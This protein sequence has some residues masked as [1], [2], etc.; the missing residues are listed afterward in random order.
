[1]F[2]PKYPKIEIMRY[3]LLFLAIPFMSAQAEAADCTRLKKIANDLEDKIERLRFTSPEYNCNEMTPKDFDLPDDS[4]GFSKD[5]EWDYRCKD[6]SAMDAQLKSI[7]N[8]IAM[9][10]GITGLKNDISQGVVTLKKFTNPEMAKEATN[11]FMKNLAVAQS[12][13]LFLGT[14]NADS[15]NILSEIVKA[16]P[17]E[18]ESY[19]SFGKLVEKFCQA[20]PIAGDSVCMKNYKI[21]QEVYEEINGFVKAGSETSRKF[22]K[23]QI[24]DFSDALGVKK[25]KE[26]YSFNQ[27]AADVK[28]GEN[29]LFSKADL[30]K[31]KD[32]PPLSNSTKFD[33]LKEMKDSLKELKESEALVGAQEIPNRFSSLINDLKKRQQFEMKSKLSLV[34]FNNA[35]KIPADL[36]DKCDQARELAIP[37]GDCLEPL[38]K[39][40]GLSETRAELNDRIEEFKYGEAHLVKLDEMLKDCIPDASLEYTAEKCDGIITSKLD[41]LVKKAAVLTKMRSKLL[42]ASPELMTLRNF[43][44]EQLESNECMAAGESNIG[45][46]SQ[47][48]GTISREVVTLSGDA[49]DV[50]LLFAKPEV[51]TDI[52]TVCAEKKEKVSHTDELCMLFEEGLKKKKVANEAT[53][54]E[55]S[56]YLNPMG[57]G[58]SEAVSDFL[59]SVTQTVSNYFKKPPQQY[60]PTNPYASIY[61]YAPMMNQQPQDISQKIMGPYMAS[62]YGSYSPTPG[63]RP[64]S[65]VNS[66]VTTYAGYS[67]GSSGRFNSAVGW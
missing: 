13:E 66:N 55:E 26:K 34:L 7:E 61:P 11:K 37:V 9:L 41:D 42:S 20:N 2:G 43:A 54:I 25:G 31:L 38:S 65:S 64:Y 45:E 53:P 14:N 3:L 21:T 67:F 44:L 63:L 51:E 57:R 49:G 62:G 8:E 50:L 40:P 59:K 33:F 4:V 36:K 30:Q 60:A 12:L 10:N 16:D 28:V 52:S 48:V 19:E 6:L 15:T 46:C 58:N 27:L 22:N 1:M 5:S 24:G 35:G 18:W 32:L 56:S 47:D 17:K 39:I 29:G 23:R